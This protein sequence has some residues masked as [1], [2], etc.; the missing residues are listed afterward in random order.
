MNGFEK[1][2][3]I[4]AAPPND[5]DL[6]EGPQI[7]DILSIHELHFSLR[8]ELELH[9]LAHET[10]GLSHFSIAQRIRSGIST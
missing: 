4:K 3:K 9:G 1:V 8:G 5:L 2:E 6:P 7:Q 10:L